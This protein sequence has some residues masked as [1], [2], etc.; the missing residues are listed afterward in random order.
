MHKYNIIL[1]GVALKRYLNIFELISGCSK[2]VNKVEWVDVG[3]GTLTS[4]QDNRHKVK[5]DQFFTS[6]GIDIGIGNSLG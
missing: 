1:I 3:L 4:L 5:L 2:L 6:E